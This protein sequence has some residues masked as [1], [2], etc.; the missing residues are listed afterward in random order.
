MRAGLSGLQ[1][2]PVEAEDG[3]PKEPFVAEQQEHSS[4]TLTL[5]D[6]SCMPLSLLYATDAVCVGVGG[7][8]VCCVSVC[9]LCV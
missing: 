4:A 9:V 7:A 1:G 5:N 2:G 6:F 3:V 8:C